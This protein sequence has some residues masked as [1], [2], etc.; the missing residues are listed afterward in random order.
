MPRRGLS[1]QELASIGQWLK[2]RGGPSK[3]PRSS[4]G[5]DLPSHEP[6]V[7]KPKRNLNGVLRRARRTRLSAKRNPQGF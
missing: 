3:C 5:L 7:R 1:N 4:T 2:E 6:V